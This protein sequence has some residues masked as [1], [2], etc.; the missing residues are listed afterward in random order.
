MQYLCVGA[1]FGLLLAKWS[2][3]SSYFALYFGLASLALL[4]LLLFGKKFV[5]QNEGILLA[6]F[7]FSLA[8]SLFVVRGQFMEENKE[9]PDALYQKQKVELH[10]KERK[11]ESEYVRY[12]ASLT[13]E[14]GE[15]AVYARLPLYPAFAIGDK[16]CGEASLLEEE[17]ALIS[18][19][20]KRTFDYASYLKERGIA[21]VYSYPKLL[22]CGEAPTT[23]LA[24]LKQQKENFSLLFEKQMSVREA[25]LAAATLFG[26]DELTKEESALYKKAGISHIVALSGFNISIVIVFLFALFFFLPFWPRMILSII[27]LTLYLLMVGVSG[28][29]LR[30]TVMAGIT[31]LFLFRG[32]KTD[33]KRVL[34]L[35]ALLLALFYPKSVLHD[36]SLQL[37][38]LAM[39]GVLFVYPIFFERL[40]MSYR[41]LSRSFL[42]L[43]L[44]TL[45]VTLL[46][47][48]YTAYLFSSISLYGMLTTVLI[49]FLVPSVTVLGILFLFFS[50]ITPITSA[51]LS[52]PLSLFTGFIIA[53]AEKVS[54][55]PS[56][57]LSY[58]VS[59]EGLLLFYA[60][61]FLVLLCTKEV[62]GE[63][64][65]D[66]L[67]Q[68]KVKKESVSESE[69]IQGTI[70]F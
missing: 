55:L 25:H 31:F 22:K 30:A 17:Q 50:L 29:L 27:V 9:T 21:G 66:T 57:T 56:N 54:E 10:L 38:F 35:S 15:Y 3:F 44:T 40:T 5:R 14:G 28:S 46:I 2:L 11:K 23:F 58:T 37:S 68:E 26:S 48:P 20:G 62:R 42:E 69:V 49:T 1:F 64:L 13:Y 67:D 32:S 16:L 63:G 61:L 51:L 45:S 33:A 8:T 18:E 47:A 59:G 53:V 60:V 34:L 6:L 70:N 36:A 65:T 19:D 4:L 24:T 7:L 41:G 52:F 43:F 39:A 12:T